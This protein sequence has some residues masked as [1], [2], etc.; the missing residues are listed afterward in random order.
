MG[1]GIIK[2]NCIGCKIC[3]PACPFGAISME[4][5]KAAIGP[6]CTLCGACVKA[7]RF[8]AIEF[9]RPKGK[10]VDKG[11]YSG[12]WVYCET[13]DGKLMGSALQ[14]LSKARELS[15]T[16][17]EKISSILVGN[18]I[19][20][21][22]ETIRDHGADRIYKAELPRIEHYDTDTYSSLVSG[23][24]IKHRPSIVLFPASNIGRDLAPRI[25]SSLGI[26]LTADCTGLS[27]DTD[28]NLVQSRPA[29]GGNIMADI[30]TP[31]HRPQMATVRP[32]VFKTGEPESGRIVS[33]VEVPVK[34]DPSSLK[35]VVKEIIKTTE[36][37]GKDITEVDVVVSGGGGLRGD[38]NFRILEELASALG[39]V[40]GAS[41]VAVDSGWRPRSDQV[42]QTG[43]T[44]SPRLYIACGISGKI[45]HQVGM[46]GSEI[47]IAINKDPD[48]PIF[49]V[50]DYGIVG[51]LFEIVPAITAEIRKMKQ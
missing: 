38:D 18:G 33:V 19:E 17:G 7:C 35:V 2:E 20:K 16:T 12:I 47:I 5:G 51:D 1:I 37:G 24:L 36:S 14:L 10:G 9:E 23:L 39:G 45:Q 46:K 48:A 21:H 28:G 15:G 6:E 43:K 30:I 4:E 29:F 26:G 27:I 50:A 25:A 11:D 40:V 13:R 22:L 42:G 3:V 34:V 32:N 44:V 8:G 41:R 31:D 49:K